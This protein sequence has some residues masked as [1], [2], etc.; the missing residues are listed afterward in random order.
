MGFLDPKVWIALA[1]AAGLAFAAGWFEGGVVPRREFAEF[2]AAA[3]ATA[4]VKEDERAG[5]EA[6][7]KQAAREARDEVL[8]T[9][10]EADAAK[11]ARDAALAREGGLVRD[12]AAA[13]RVLSAGGGSQASINPP[14]SLRGDPPDSGADL[15]GRLEACRAD[16][17][18][19]TDTLGVN[20]DNH[21]LALAARDACV[22][23]Y[24][25]VRALNNE[26]E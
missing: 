2:K 4:K 6:G 18:V 10:R 7:A 11:R 20:K 21:K 14:A 19:L 17:T 25:A 3:A 5:I 26:K 13:R 24:N 23:Q 9:Q 12:V 22:R 1:I 8:A 15:A 16:L